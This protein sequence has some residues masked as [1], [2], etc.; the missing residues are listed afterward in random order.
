MIFCKAKRMDDQATLH[1]GST[2]TTCHGFCAP[3]SPILCYCSRA[4]TSTP[5]SF[6]LS[7]APHRRQDSA[8]I[9]A[10]LQQLAPKGPRQVYLR[11]S[12][13]PGGLRA[14]KTAQQQKNRTRVRILWARTKMGLELAIPHTDS[15]KFSSACETPLDCR[16]FVSA[17]TCQSHI[18]CP[19][20]SV[21]TL[22]LADRVAVEQFHSMSRTR[23]P[24][25]PWNPGEGPYSPLKRPSNPLKLF[26]SS[27]ASST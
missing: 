2:G 15:G 25:P 3:P 27:W 5:A 1:S 13:S 16:I 17:C 22:L 20:S 21:R 4:A 19:R 11:I 26:Q 18:S 23:Y 9:R 8:T 14:G 10:I 24:Q 12:L 7:S 6:V